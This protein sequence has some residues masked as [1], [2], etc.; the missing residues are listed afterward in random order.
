M[1]S[2]IKEQ[3]MLNSQPKIKVIGE[4]SET[5]SIPNMVGSIRNSTTLS[6]YKDNEMRIMNDDSGMKDSPEIKFSTIKKQKKELS[7]DPKLSKKLFGNLT[8]QDM[9][10]QK[11]QFGILGYEINPRPRYNFIRKHV[12]P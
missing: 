10:Q 9:I 6:T 1:A 8:V 2:Q 5:K 11:E 3:P 4:A 7:I 12:I